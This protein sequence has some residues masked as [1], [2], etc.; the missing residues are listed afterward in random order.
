MVQEC[1]IDCRMNGLFAESSKKMPR[2]SSRYFDT[3]QT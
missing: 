3:V 2:A 1:V